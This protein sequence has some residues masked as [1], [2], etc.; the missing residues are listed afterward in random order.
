LNEHEEFFREQNELT[1]RRL[2]ELDELKK[3]GVNPYVYG[4]PVDSYSADILI[5]FMDDAPPVSVAVAGRVMSLRRMGKASFCHV[6]DPK[7]RIQIYLKSD[8]L[9]KAYDQF[10]LMDIGDIIGVKGFVFR[11]KTGEI[12]IHAKSLELLSKSVRPLPIVKEKV[13][14]KGNKSSMIHSQTKNFGTDSGMSISL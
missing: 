10:K 14:D 5:S 6:Q 2:E 1:K 7:G 12:S 3:G 11:T 9:G 4:F 8:D 13:D